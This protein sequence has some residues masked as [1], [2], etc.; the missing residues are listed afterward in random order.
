V[1]DLRAIAAALPDDPEAYVRLLGLV[2]HRGPRRDTTRVLCPW[3]SEKKPSCDVTVLPGRIG[4]R[5]RSCNAGGDHLHLAAA[6]W[7]ID[8]RGAGFRE[9]AL[10]LADLLGV[11]AADTPSAERPKPQDP[12]V[13]LAKALERAATDFLDGRPIH[14]RD[15]S[16]IDAATDRQVELSTRLIAASLRRR[17]FHEVAQEVLDDLELDRLADAFHAQEP[18]RIAREL[19]ATLQPSKAA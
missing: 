2:P 7:G 8:P 16:T 15:A 1:I 18:A 10:R 5:C 3:H 12:L 9:T 14:P 11:T 4:A 13:V 17:R 6:A 19:D